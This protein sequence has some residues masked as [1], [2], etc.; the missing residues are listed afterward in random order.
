MGENNHLPLIE[1]DSEVTAIKENAFD[2]DS[3]E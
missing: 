1:K 3:G 2:T